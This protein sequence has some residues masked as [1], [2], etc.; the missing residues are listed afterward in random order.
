MPTVF[1]SYSHLDQKWCDPAYSFVLIPWLENALRRDGVTLWYD[2][3]DTTG[4]QPGAQFEREIL[5]AIDAAQVALLMVSEAFFASDFIRDVEL[6]RILQRAAE[7]KLVVIP[8]LLEPCDWHDFDY[9]A[10]RQMLPGQ[11]TP[12]I[13]YTDSDRHWAHARDQVLSG[14]RRRIRPQ[15]EPA[16]GEQPRR[17]FRWTCQPIRRH[18]RRTRRERSIGAGSV[19]LLW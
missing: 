19:M 10:S 16:Y 4:I 3:S 6:P 8:I 12:L 13:D 5:A 18:P 11:P 14:I 7:N 15:S 9:V 17:Q 2:R 1:V